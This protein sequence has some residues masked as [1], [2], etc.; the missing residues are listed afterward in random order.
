MRQTHVDFVAS[1]ASSARTGIV[2]FVIGTLL[3]GAAVMDDANR[4]DELVQLQVSLKKAKAVSR[5]MEAVRAPDH[6]IGLAG[7]RQSGDINRRLTSPWSELLDALEHAQNDSIALL[8]IEPNAE[9]G[10]LRLSGEAKDMDALVGYIRSLDG[11]AGLSE[12]RLLTQQAKQSD[13][14]HPVEFVLESHWLQKPPRS[15]V[16]EASS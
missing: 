7:V 1:S 2:L 9:Q 13:P 11:K 3:A 8:A 4:S 14:Q 10:K 16:M 12:L 5:R 6:G 15:M